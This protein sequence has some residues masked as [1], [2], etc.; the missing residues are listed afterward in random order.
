LSRLVAI[1]LGHLR[2]AVDQVVDGLL[3]IVSA[4]FPFG[5]EEEL[6]LDRNTKNLTQAVEKMLHAAGIPLDIKMNDTRRPSAHAIYAATSA[7]LGHPIIFRTY[8]SR[9]TRINPTITEAICATM[10]MPSFFSPVK[11][12]PPMREQ[13]Y[14]G[15]AHGTNNPTREV[16]KEAS[17][18]F[19]KDARVAQVLSIGSGRTR[20][21][22]LDQS[23]TSNAIIQLTKDMASD[24]ELVARELSTRL[25]GVRAYIRLNVDRGMETVKMNDWTGLGTIGSH[26]SA[27]L[28]ST[29]IDE[30][31]EASV[32]RIQER[33]GSA[34]L[35]QI[36]MSF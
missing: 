16:L 5:V 22:S 14:V 2:M 23:A 1:M 17:N 31:I 3:A 29:D 12:G 33:V 25:F 6:D 11:I 28:E 18:I 19:G 36:S 34:T 9:G 7:N 15:S 8:R 13:T 27:Y 30:A 35:G 21:L 10:A 24:C 20:V 26:T 4:V 32:E